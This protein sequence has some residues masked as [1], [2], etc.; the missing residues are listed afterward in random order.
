MWS[1]WTVRKALTAYQDGELR[2]GKAQRI[3]DHLRTCAPCHR[4]LEELQRVTILL[5]TVRE[6][7]REPGY[8]PQAF[9]RLRGKIQRLPPVPRAPLLQHLRRILQ[10]PALALIPVAL[11]GAALANTLVFLGLEQ[12]ACAFL[13]SYLLPIVLD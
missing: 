10:S 5:R 12:E 6:P 9:I 4:E 2:H 13:S 7:S 1:C 8:W 11:M 3:E